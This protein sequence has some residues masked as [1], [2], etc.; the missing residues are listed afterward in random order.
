MLPCSEIGIF[1]RP[2]CASRPH[3]HVDVLL[4]ELQNLAD[5]FSLQHYGELWKNVFVEVSQARGTAKLILSARSAVNAHKAFV[6]AC[7]GADLTLCARASIVQ[8][9]AR[10]GVEPPKFPKHDNDGLV[11]LAPETVHWMCSAIWRIIGSSPAARVTLSTEAMRD[12][13][14][15]AATCVVMTSDV[16][17]SVLSVIVALTKG[18]DTTFAKQLFAT[19]SVRDALVGIAAHVAA[20][21][22]AQL[23]CKALCNIIIAPDSKL[24]FAT[25]PMRDALVHVSQFATSPN[26]VEWLARA[27]CSLTSSRDRSIIALLGRPSFRDM[28]TN[29]SCGALT[30][31]AT[32]WWSSAIFN[33][34]SGQNISLQTMFA[35]SA[36]YDAFV[37]VGR[38]ATSSSALRWWAEAIAPLTRRDVSMKAKFDSNEIRDVLVTH[39]HGVAGAS[40]SADTLHSIASAFSSLATVTTAT[41]QTDCVRDAFIVILSNSY[42]TALVATHV[43]RAIAVL[44]LHG[45]SS[46]IERF[47]T[48]EALDAMILAANKAVTTP[49][50]VVQFS[51]AVCHLTGSPITPP[52]ITERCGSVAMRDAFIAMSRYA[53]TPDAVQWLLSAIKNVVGSA[54]R[55]VHA[56]F[57]SSTSIRD[58]LFELLSTT[59]TNTASN[60]TATLFFMIICKLLHGASESERLTFATEAM[61]NLLIALS[62]YAN[63]NETVK[64]FYS[65][66]CTLVT[67]RSFHDAPCGGAYDASHFA[68]IEMRDALLATSR[69][70]TYAEAAF[71]MC[72][73]TAA[74]TSECPINN[75]VPSKGR[76]IFATSPA[77]H[78][79]MIRMSAWATEMEVIQVIAT[80]V[81]QLTE[82]S[83]V[84]AKACFGT[85]A[86]HDVLITMAKHAT[87]P[88]AARWIVRAT[89]SLT[90]G[91]DAPTRAKIETSSIQNAL[92]AMRRR[93]SLFGGE[94][95]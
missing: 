44:T 50:A 40:T 74:L 84:E 93:F 55:V 3:L 75:P 94:V 2:Q 24:L 27:I 69:Y 34:T 53:T 45:S 1:G 37:V 52:V 23:F 14:V 33:I 10:D 15:E 8:R 83:D 11:L 57:A 72:N 81:C 35:T 78:D 42:T 29:V 80:V 12:A 71:W 76:N 88:N 49:E 26:S 61:R 4:K 22:A 82:G 77:V 73:A 21:D 70:V 48:T 51:I 58:M 63:G 85:T 18:F 56:T 6:S 95:W 62:H 91:A 28:L 5:F 9:N 67:R 30:A 60:G 38:N 87:T 90:E 7:Q 25:E 41:F 89:L 20:P 65:A 68:T 16:A 47:A 36:M 32:Q 86:M 54:S 43:F 31:N 79:A 17:N 39:T 64:W 92:Q 66:I 13:V 46:V 19:E 59:T